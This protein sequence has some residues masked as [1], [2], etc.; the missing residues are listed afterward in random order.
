MKIS[1]IENKIIQL[2]VLFCWIFLPVHISAQATVYVNPAS[3]VLSGQSTVTIDFMISNVIDLHAY[4]IRVAFN[5][6]I[7]QLNNVSQGPF[8]SA[9]G[10]TFFSTS[11]NPIIDSMEIAEAILGTNTVNGSGKLFSITFN[12]LSAGGSPINI[13]VV[14]LRDHAN[15]NI[16]VSWS[17][18]EV[19][20]PL[21]INT[22]IYLQGPFNGS[23]LNTILNSSG[24]LPLSQPYLSNPWNYNGTE[25]VPLGFFTTHS[26]IVDWVL[27]ELRTGTGASTIVDRKAGFV[28]DNGNILSVDGV[29]SLYFNKP[30][31]NYYMVIYHRNHISI[32]SAYLINLDYIS[33]QHDFTS[34][35]SKAFG[36][37]AMFNL[38]AG[39]FGMYAADANGN[40]QVQNNDIEN[41]W[42]PQ[43]GQS[44]YKQADFNLNG[45]VQN[46]DKETY[47]APNNGKGTQVPN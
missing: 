10:S 12:V 7:V 9:G 2:L 27:V 20:V 40:G 46:N 39:I 43:N 8:L 29:S 22:K 31:G 37:N 28:I 44:G 32:M 41:Y 25:S 5:N 36:E 35:Q 11:P 45:Q 3:I 21:S 18:G 15:L 14:Q 1:L 23:N 30:K 16:P 4:S 47:W 13:L 42:L 6:S 33:S 26:N 38:G 24:Y 19:T 34:A 17:S